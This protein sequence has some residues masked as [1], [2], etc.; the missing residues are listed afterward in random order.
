MLT[1]AKHNLHLHFASPCTHFTILFACNTSPLHARWMCDI[2]ALTGAIVIDRFV[3]IKYW[4]RCF[5][6]I[7]WKSN[8]SHTNVG[9]RTKIWLESEVAKFTF[10]SIMSLRQMRRPMFVPV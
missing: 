9:V 2:F 7:F 1:V 6:A 3:E 10:H 5:P 4:Q 8:P